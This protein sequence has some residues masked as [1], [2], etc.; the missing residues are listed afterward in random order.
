MISSKILVYH[1]PP[2]SSS[3]EVYRPARRRK[4]SLGDLFHNGFRVRSGPGALEKEETQGFWQSVRSCCRVCTSWGKVPLNPSTYLP[5]STVYLKRLCRGEALFL[6][7]GFRAL[8]IPCKSI[9]YPEGLLR[10]EGPSLQ[11]G[12]RV[13]PGG[14]VIGCSIPLCLAYPLHA[15]VPGQPESPAFLFR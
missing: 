2:S 14:L 12:F 3:T 9:L 15:D 10:K 8:L 6:Q 1:H 4:K 11:A 7:A 5:D 13:M